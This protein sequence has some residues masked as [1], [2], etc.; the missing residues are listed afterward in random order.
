MLK[1]FTGGI[2]PIEQGDYRLNQLCRLIQSPEKL[3]NPF[4][5]QISTKLEEYKK[6]P[7]PNTHIHPSLYKIKLNE[8]NMHV[9]VPEFI[10][11]F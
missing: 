7:E 11:L 8:K 3:I 1:H 6:P 5:T 10:C 2:K 9:Y 4:E